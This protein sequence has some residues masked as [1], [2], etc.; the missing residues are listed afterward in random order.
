MTIKKAYLLLI[1]LLLGFNTLTNAQVH[2]VYFA[3]VIKEGGKEVLHFEWRSDYPYYH[4]AIISDQNYNILGEVIFPNKTFDLN[5]LQ[6]H[7]TVL[8]TAVSPTGTPSESVRVD[9]NKDYSS[10]LATREQEQIIVNKHTGGNAAFVGANSGEEFIAK[11]VNFCGIRLG[12]HDT[13]QPDIVAKQAHLDRI[14]YLKENSSFTVHNVKIGDVIQFY[15]PYRTETLMR[16]M[17]SQGYNLVRVFLKTGQRGSGQTEVWGMSGPIQT[18]GL[19]MPYMDNFVD[20][21]TRAQSY[22]IYVMPC[23]TENEMMDNYEFRELSKGASGQSILFSEDGIIAKQHYIELVL[24]YI[25]DIDPSLIN[26]LFALTMQNEFAWHSYE[27][28]FDQTSGTYTFL[29]GSTYDMSSDDERRALANV[30]IQNYYS[31]MKEVVEANAPGLL[32]GEGTFAMGSVGKTYENSKGIR[33]VNGVNDLRFPMTAVEYLNTDI[34]FL[35]FHIYRW[36]QSGTGADVFDYFA[37]NMKVKTPECTELMKSKPIVMGEFGSFKENEATIEEAITFT[38][39]LKDAALDYGFK[40][41]VYWTINTFEQSR[42]WNM[43]FDNGKML[44]STG[45]NFNEPMNETFLLE[46]EANASANWTDFYIRPPLGDE[47]Q[48]DYYQLKLQF[49]GGE[50]KLFNGDHQEGLAAGTYNTN[51]NYEFRVYMDADAMKQK[52][53]YRAEG[54]FEWT[55]L[56]DG[57][58]WAYGYVPAG[59]IELSHDHLSITNVKTTPLYSLAL[60]VNDGTDPVAGATVIMGDETYSSDASG[61]VTFPNLTKGL[62]EYT[63]IANGFGEYSNQVILDANHSSTV[64]LSTGVN[65]NFSEQNNNFL[66][67]FNAKVTNH[68]CDF[69]IKPPMGDAH[70]D[71]YY[72]VH[73][74]FDNGDITLFNTENQSGLTAESGYSL[75]QSY[76]FRVYMDSGNKTQTIAYKAQQSGEWITLFSDVS[77]AYG[78][79]PV[80]RIVT[81]QNN[82]TISNISIERVYDV[83]IVVNGNGAA[84]EGATVVLDGETLLTDENGRVTFFYKGFGTYMYSVAAEGFQSLDGNITV[85]SRDIVKQLDLIKEVNYDFGS[86]TEDFLLEFDVIVAGNGEMYI[87]PPT[88]DAHQDDYYQ[89]RMSFTDGVI[90]WHN[91]DM[92]SGFIADSGYEFF[93]KYNFKLNFNINT[94]KVKVEFKA[95]TETRY[96]TLFEG[97]SFAY[98][99]S[100]VGR[101][102]LPDNNFLLSNITVNGVS[103]DI[104]SANDKEET[105]VIYPNPVQNTLH[106]NA[107]SELESIKVFSASGKLMMQKQLST[108]KGY[109]LN[110]STLGT[111]IY[112]IQVGSRQGISIRQI[113][114]K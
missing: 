111:G 2:P 76:D 6:G 70:Q 41:T 104:T 55:V 15:D 8:I 74:L 37:E 16:T 107:Q 13:F 19:H 61:N 14:E 103:T 68:G 98:G 48:D 84:L 54:E 57:V 67:E 46:F 17:K 40:G 12:D 24:K 49:A 89:M 73:L 39:E 91:G 36:G 86:M 69:Y 26:T 21:L 23:F 71:D 75:D 100:P 78:Y 52:I 5:K 59:R 112:F 34:D 63:V 65:Y 53:S 105:F 9:L 3:D 62:Y 96:T 82:M 51:K 47:H 90:K 80:G 20:F 77:W 99:Y 31:R 102:V 56:Y 29:D 92:P 4:K 97:V 83:D 27:A 64:T 45:L 25:K 81:G 114:K 87:K 108:V 106:I 44:K 79:T 94:K 88:G 30:A 85:T 18:E 35:D 7:Q 42:L 95:D 110:V 72:Q 109:S 60:T 33:P 38:Q 113:I 58:S 22:G 32:I 1:P 66:L 93:Q 50:F 43:M 10:L 11:G 101:F 28:P